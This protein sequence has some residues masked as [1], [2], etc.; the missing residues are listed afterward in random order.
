MVLKTGYTKNRLYLQI[1][2]KNRLYLSKVYLFLKK[3]WYTKN[4][5]YLSKSSKNRLYQYNRYNRFPVIPFNPVREVKATTQGATFSNG[6]RLQI[7]C[8]ADDIMLISDNPDDLQK[9]I[10]VCYNYACHHSFKFSI[11]KS[12]IMIIHHKPKNHKNLK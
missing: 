2:L 3:K 10:D 4:R 1:F 11:K 6:T 12:K 7:L 8:F 5:L 9:M